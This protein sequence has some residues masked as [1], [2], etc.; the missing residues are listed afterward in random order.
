[1]SYLRQIA[2]SMGVACLFLSSPGCGNALGPDALS[3]PAPQAGAFYWVRVRYDSASPERMERRVIAPLEAELT[4]LPELA[5]IVTNYTDR[6]VEM[7]LHARPRTRR[8]ILGQ[9]LQIALA[10]A[11]KVLP[12]GAWKPQLLDHDPLG[13]L[14]ASPQAPGFQVEDF[15]VC[16]DPRKLA[17]YGLTIDEVRK[18][19][20]DDSAISLPGDENQGD[21]APEL[22]KALAQAILVDGQRSVRLRDVAEI[23]PRSQAPQTG[24]RVRI[25]PAPQR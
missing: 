4:L 19:I 20:R 16:L 5:R 23:Y 10:E 8:Q 3:Q 18:K 25:W 1:M 11:A 7:A 21:R 24:A 14:L 22:S 6:Q 9:K 12:E 13:T 15:Q 2:A 17:R